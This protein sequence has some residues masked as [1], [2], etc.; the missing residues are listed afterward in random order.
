MMNRRGWLGTM[1]GG[2]AVAGVFGGMNGPTPARAEDEGRMVAENPVRLR[3]C[4]QF[5]PMPGAN[6]QEKI[7][8]AVKWGLDAM[9]LPGGVVGQVEYFKSLIKDTPL[10][11]SAVCFGS[12][13]G[14]LVSEN[15]SR[16][17]PA[18]DEL[19][20]VLEAAGE[21]GSTGVIYVPAFNGQTKLTN[22]EI[23]EI[24]LDKLP[25][26]GEFA[27]KCGTRILFEPLNRG[28]A[29]F[30][31][32]VA[33]GAAIAFDCKS[34]GICVMGDL[35]H[36]GREETSACGAF[37]SAGKRLHHVHLA[38]F[39]TRQM[40]GT[41]PGDAEFYRSGFCGLKMIGYDKFCS[42]ECGC[43]GEEDFLKS[44]TF[45]RETWDKADPAAEFGWVPLP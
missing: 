39:P 2:A 38:S 40:P 44:L 3:L 30:L 22:Q 4:S 24:L 45:L 9:E 31:R 18:M 32:Q 12:M 16:R 36:M 41:D 21:L 34:D 29:Y 13:G 11:Y 5:G 42:F 6:D 1:A 23:R 35:Y 8:N 10:V 19:K 28:E 25:E 37:I 17:G 43:R 15:K 7:A 33:D 27:V 14:A 26:I 20:Q